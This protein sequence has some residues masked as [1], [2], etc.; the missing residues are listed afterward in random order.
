MP[1][2]LKN[3]RVIAALVVLAGVFIATVALLRADGGSDPVPGAQSLPAVPTSTDS[4]APRGAP[5]HWLP[6]EAW[7]YNH[8][9]PYDEGLLYSLLEVSRGTIWRHLRDDSTP[10][11]ELAATRGWPDPGK[12]ADA[13]VAPSARGL[14]DSMRSKLRSRALRTL[15]QGHL[16]QHVFFHSLHQ[17]AIPSA[18]PEIFGVTDANFRQLRRGEQ[19]PLEIG[20]LRGRSPAAIERR[21]TDVLR[22]RVEYG[23]RTNAMTAQQGKLLLRRQLSQLPRWLSQARYNGPPPTKKGKLTSKPRDYAANPA[24]SADGEHVTYQAYLQKVPKAVK[25]GEIS[26]RSHPLDGGEEIDASLR[27]GGA[28]PRSAYNPTVSG[29]GRLIAYESSEGNLNFAKRYGEIR[30]V[31]YDTV[32]RRARRIAPVKAKPGASRSEYN[33]ALSAN[34]RKLAYQAVRGRG[35]SAVYVTDL[36]SDRTTLVSRAT[37]SA[38]GA[39][40][41]VYHPSISGDG[42]KVAFVSAASNLG[43]GSRGGSTQVFLR[44]LDAG[45]TTVVSRASGARGAVADDYSSDPSISR[46]GRYVAFSSSAGNLGAGKGGSRIYVRDLVQQR[47]VV[48]SQSGDG[49]ALKPSISARGERVAYAAF[50][51]ERSRVLVRDTSGDGPA[52][53]VSRAGG[54]QGAIADGNADN[55]S[56]SADGRTVAFESTATN[57]AKAKSAGTRGVFARDL[58]TNATKLVSAPAAAAE[59]DRPATGAPSSMLR[60]PAPRKLKTL[61]DRKPQTSVVSVF[62]NAF[63]RGQDRPT[64]RLATGGVLTWRFRSRQ[65]HQVTSLTGPQRVIVAPRTSGTYSVRINKPGTYKFVCTIHAPGMKM[66]AV[67]G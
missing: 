3:A 30:I 64:V 20:R 22:G 29:D 8:W 24:L 4:E 58:R 18:A 31:V 35:Q 11:A 19:S 65:S 12:L 47:T 41:G 33:P 44:D 27:E 23:V 60:S 56:I 66:T 46:D 43:A 59:G 14:S 10:L 7:V 61:P 48:V 25:Q 38:A 17:F 21:S 34:G 40:D 45:T 15:T 67:V 39:N 37:R 54:A 62:D 53:I 2:S 52:E 1:G 63:H 36:R 32:K 50:T 13:L 55:A 28:T 9:L 5:A 57:L 51:D 26:V 42:S 49:F 6:P 16:A